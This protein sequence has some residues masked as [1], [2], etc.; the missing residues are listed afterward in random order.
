MKHPA[1]LCSLPRS[2]RSTRGPD[3]K[4]IIVAALVLFIAP[5]R[6]VS[7]EDPQTAKLNEL[8]GRYIAGDPPAATEIDI[9]EYRKLKTQYPR[10]ENQ[11]THDLVLDSFDESS[12]W[13]SVVSQ[14]ASKVWQWEKRYKLRRDAVTDNELGIPQILRASQEIKGVKT[15]DAESSK[16]LGQLLDNV[17]KSLP[18]GWSARIVPSKQDR[19]DVP[20]LLVSR[21]ARISG[22]YEM[23]NRPPEK[24]VSQAS[25]IV[26]HFPTMPY[27]TPEEHSAIAERNRNKQQKRSEFEKRLSNIKWGWMGGRPFPPSAYSPMNG[28]E[29]ELVRE[30]AFLWQATMPEALPD[31]YFQTLSFKSDVAW[32][33]RC[34]NAKDQDELDKVRQTVVAHFQKYME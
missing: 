27:L 32:G 14:H 11:T 2:A 34:E 30:Y 7:A 5:C 19:C 6:A 26:F 12:L 22:W 4:S 1:T 10:Q 31:L 3:I 17:R 8:A 20:A 25:E 33:F 16:P 23:P 28:A 24:P 15:T 29:E 13:V 9:K 18:A 21:D